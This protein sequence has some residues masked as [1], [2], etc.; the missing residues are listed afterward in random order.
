MVLIPVKVWF[1]AEDTRAAAG[2]RELS[3]LEKNMKK[4]SWT[5]A[6]VA[7]LLL[8]S[9]LVWAES[10]A[11]VGDTEISRE[12][13]E[14]SVRPKLIEL[15]N[16]RYETL[17]QGLEELVGERLFEL[18]A[19]ERGKT[20]E[21]LRDEEIFSKVAEPGEDE[22]QRVY[23]ENKA[24]IGDRTLDELRPQIVQFLKQRT[25]NM[26]YQALLKDLRKKYA[27][28]TM[29]SPPVVDVSTGGRPSRGGGDNAPVTLIEFA[30]YECPYCKLVQP[31]VEQVLETY[32][33][34]VRYVY[35]DF[36]LPF[37]SH[38]RPAS[39]AARCAEEQGKYWEYHD[40]LF[41]APDLSIDGLRSLADTVGLDR[42]K[43]DDC[44]A[45]EKYDD[46]IDKDVSEG[47]NA[48]VNGTPA[49]FINGRFLSGALPFDQLK[50]VIDEELE[51]AGG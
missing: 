9:S 39:L 29:L 37:H 38:A 20:A 17:R 18:E 13:L 36:P 11:K 34:K 1:S 15:E 41:E 35:R 24:Q 7:T 48:G 10:V 12:E 49:F 23:D 5:V 2:T 21:E 26:L 33:D 31:A 19:K 27:V 45:S 25:A 51:R 44:L 28:K 47:S 30:D 40:A 32:G 14:K 42:T 3:Q 43:F 50:T 6:A 8:T 4:F 16:Q 46:A 22:I